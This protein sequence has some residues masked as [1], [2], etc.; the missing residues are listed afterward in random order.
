MEWTEEKKGGGEVEI[1]GRANSFKEFYSEEQKTNGAWVKGG[2]GA[3]LAN[4]TFPP[5]WGS[6]VMLL[7]SWNV[8]DELR[9]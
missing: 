1:T 5:Q 8:A 6:S 4:R 9:S 7:G 2:V 3:A